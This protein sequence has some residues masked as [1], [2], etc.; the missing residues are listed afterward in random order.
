[1]ATAILLDRS[2]EGRLVVAGPD[3]VTFLQRIL[4]QDIEPVAAGSGTESFFLTP[5]GKYAV[6][7]TLHNRGDHFLVKCPAAARLEIAK[8]LSMYTLGSEADV[9]DATE[10]LSLLSVAGPGAADVLAAAGA[11][12]LPEEL[13]ASA[14][15]P[16]GGYEVTACRADDLGLDGWDLHFPA[17][18]RDAVEGA[19]TSA[20]AEP[21]DGASAEVIRIEA[22]VPRHGVEMDDKLLPPEI[23]YLVPRAI[24]YT[25]GCYIGQE[26]I[27]RIKTYGHVNRELRGLVVAGDTPPAPGTEVFVGEKKV[28]TV[29]SSCVS[30]SV[31]GPI[32]LAFIKRQHFE[33]GTEVTLT[34]EGATTTGRVVVA[35]GPWA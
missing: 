34:I 26:T 22:G 30:E 29:T 10:I 8:K 20:G 17:S 28:G 35:G 12:G 7:M 11:T 27:A 14:M 15:V 16:I 31:G 21:L 25:K 6:L 24:S 9:Q 13:H 18:I 33:V 2:D 19:L 1:M 23:P 4:T 5:K 3:S 32:A